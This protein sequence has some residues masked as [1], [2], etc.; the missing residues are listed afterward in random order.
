MLS[1]SERYIPFWIFVNTVRT[2]GLWSG[3]LFP[4]RVYDF[5]MRYW[6]TKR[7]VHQRRN[8]I[9]VFFCSLHAARRQ[10]GIGSYG[11]SRKS[12]SACGCGGEVLRSTCISR[13]CGCSSPGC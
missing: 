3:V 12:V 8:S 10:I 5:R 4:Q 11:I 7:E 13:L 9:D 2:L 6:P 1:V